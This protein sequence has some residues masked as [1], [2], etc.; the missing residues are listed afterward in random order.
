MPNVN[1]ELEGCIYNIT[2]ICTE[3][4]IYLNTYQGTDGLI[5]CYSHEIE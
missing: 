4:E 1:C 2:G 3:T 5:V